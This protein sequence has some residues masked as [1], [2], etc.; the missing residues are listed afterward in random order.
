MGLARPGGSPALRGGQAAGSTL[1]PAGR[2]AAGRKQPFLTRGG[3]G[4]SVRGFLCGRGGGTVLANDMGPFLGGM[5]AGE[6][7]EEALRE[8]LTGVKK[9]SPAPG[10]GDLGSASPW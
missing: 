1:S 8:E 5:G 9:H 3:N 10:D 4:A 6:Q 7:R 2:G